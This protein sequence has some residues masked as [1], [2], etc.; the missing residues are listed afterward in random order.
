M[1]KKLDA[2]ILENKDCQ[3]RSMDW[4]HLY[5]M[6]IPANLS[7][8]KD[9]V[10]ELLKEIYGITEE[11]KGKKKRGNLYQV[12]GAD[13]ILFAKFNRKKAIDRYAEVDSHLGKT[14]IFFWKGDKNRIIEV[15]S[16]HFRVYEE[17]PEKYKLTFVT[18]KGELVSRWQTH[19]LPVISS[20]KKA[21][22]LGSNGRCKGWIIEIDGCGGPRSLDSALRTPFCSV[23]L[24]N[25]RDLVY[26][27]QF[28]WPFWRVMYRALSYGPNKVRIEY[29]GKR[30]DK[31]LKRLV[32]PEEKA[33]SVINA[34][35]SKKVWKFPGAL[36]GNPEVK[37]VYEE[38]QSRKG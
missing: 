24:K 3:S 26:Y 25:R 22:N 37:K 15:F 8:I 17:V 32:L 16:K 29:Y 19:R 31:L 2:W 28:G 13:N 10:I 14:F 34:Q 21:D 20:I 11:R 27:R 18:K 35:I 38:I 9:T 1:E 6:T 30:V 12:S 36:L 33:E 5:Y 4:Y 23:A 7:E